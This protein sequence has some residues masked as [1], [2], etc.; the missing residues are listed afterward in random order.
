[1]EHE[2]SRQKKSLA[3]RLTSPAGYWSLAATGVVL[4]VVMMAWLL[5]NCMS[6]P[7]LSIERSDRIELTPVQIQSIRDIGQ[8][9]FLSV[10]DEELVD[11]VRKGLF[12]DD[13]LVRIYY[14]TMRLGIDL[15]KVSEGWIT[16]S[17]DSVVLTLPPVG[18]LDERFI[19][20]ARTQSFHESGRWSAR[21]R[22]ALYQKARRQMLAHGLTPQNLRSAEDN[23]DAQFRRLLRSMGFEQVIIRFG[24][25]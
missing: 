16:T 19:D 24:R 11:T 21:D 7:L 23:A 14:G 4:L 9:E 18:L 25:E 13:H 8:W 1:M 12:R 22:E 17:G 15:A 6:E 5:R 2:N 3:E 20:E 10:T